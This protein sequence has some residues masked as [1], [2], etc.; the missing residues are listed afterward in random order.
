MKKFILA[1]LILL[2]CLFPSQASFENALATVHDIKA[3]KKVQNAYV[4][5]VE[6]LTSWLFSEYGALVIASSE[7]VSRT[8][9]GN[10]FISFDLFDMVDII[11]HQILNMVIKPNGEIVRGCVVEIPLP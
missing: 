10:F 1:T 2:T 3:P 5:E 4:A 7:N 6:G 11:P 9:G 8:S